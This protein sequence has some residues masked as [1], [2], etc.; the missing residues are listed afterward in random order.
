MRRDAIATMLPAAYQRAMHPSGVLWALLDVMEALHE[1]AEDRLDTVEDLFH[2]YRTPDRLV[3]FLARWVA[4]DHLGSGRDLVAHGT[5]LAQSRGTR[6]GLRQAVTLATG[7]TEIEIEEPADRPFHL[8]VRIPA[9]SD[10][11]ER[12]RH[13]V[14]LDKPAA[15]TF[16]MG[17]LP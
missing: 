6:E 15:T 11:T 9:G 1:A 3:P 14:E 7:L 2:P 12:V 8:I 5:A 16:E 13:I 10:L 17:T 4:V